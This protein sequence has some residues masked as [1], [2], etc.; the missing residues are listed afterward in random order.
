MKSISVFILLIYWTIIIL[1]P[2]LA[3][4]SQIFKKKPIIIEKVELSM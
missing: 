4:E 2:V 1:A 3:K